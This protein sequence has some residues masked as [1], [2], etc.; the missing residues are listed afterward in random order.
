[1]FQEPVGDIVSKRLWLTAKLM[2]WVMLVMVPMALLIGV[3]AGMREGSRLDRSLSTFSIAAAT[4]GIP[5]PAS[6]ALLGRGGRVATRRR[7]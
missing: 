3:A 7:R 5:A 6:A 4:A 1:M 2:F